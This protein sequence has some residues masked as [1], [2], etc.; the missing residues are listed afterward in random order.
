[1]TLEAHAFL[2]LRLHGDIAQLGEHCV[3]IAGVGGSSPPISTNITPDPRLLGG[4]CYPPARRRERTRSRS[5]ASAVVLGASG[6]LG[7]ATVQRL[8]EREIEVR[9]VGRQL[10]SLEAMFPEEA[11]EVMEADPF[12]QESLAE[13]C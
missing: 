9:A 4:F 7:S 12:D 3:R 8:L 13:A 6:G 10:E 11:V 1:M 5:V 2:A